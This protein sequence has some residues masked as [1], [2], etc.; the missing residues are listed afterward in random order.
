MLEITTDKT[1]EDTLAAAVN[2]ALK[3][4]KIVIAVN[5][6]ATLK[7]G[8]SQYFG[9]CESHF[10][11]SHYCLL[12]YYLRYVSRCLS[13]CQPTELQGRPGVH[14]TR[15]RAACLWSLQDFFR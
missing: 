13:A 14:T 9:L 5:V 12:L 7:V 2:V 4:G 1:S 11:L 10:H 3:Q 8:C 6:V 15:C